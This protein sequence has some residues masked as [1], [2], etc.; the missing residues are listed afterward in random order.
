MQQLYWPNTVQ[1]TLSIQHSS[2]LMLLLQR[3]AL[4]MIE[5]LNVTNEEIRTVLPLDRHKSV[6]NI[7]LCENDLRQ[8]G[9][10]TRLRSLLL[11]YFTLTDVIILIGSLSMPLL[12]QL[13]L[14]DLYDH[15][16]DHLDKFQ[17]LCGTTYLPSLKNLHFSFC[18]P[19]EM[20]YAWR[21]SPFSYNGQWPF[22]NIDYYID[23]YLFVVDDRVSLVTKT[24]LIIYKHPINVLLRHKRTLHNHRFAVHASNPIIGI[25]RRS[26]ELTCNQMDN[27]DQLVKTLQVITSSHLNEFH[28]TYLHEYTNISITSS[29]PSSCDLLFSHL[30][31]MTFEFKSESIE[32]SHR[33]AIVKQILDASPNLSHLKIH[34]KDFRHC[35][36]TYSNLKHVH[37]VLDR[38]FPEP[39]QHINVRQ[40][41]QLVPH[42]YSLE[43][44]DAN[45]IYD[46]NL[47][48][49]VLKI[50]HRFHQLVYLRLNKDGLYPVKEEKKIMF[51][52]RLIAAGHNRLFDCNNIQIEFPGYNGLC[53]WL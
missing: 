44:S 25:R 36:Q 42:L 12:E 29:Y 51:K 7:Q 5:H 14:V 11:R 45:I 3:G 52:E 23:D 8:I 41:T 49:F 39:K 10:G 1:L 27:T 28:L 34:W 20:E 38:L 32:R 17:E 4:P 46:E 9:D 31:S 33:V 21:I 19:Q 30:R 53:I 48:K 50:I 37:F 26:L 18:F 16:L 40:L 13:I 2:E 43:T 6:G 35:S 47:V 15:K 24:L 22:D